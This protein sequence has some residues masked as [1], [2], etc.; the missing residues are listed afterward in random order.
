MSEPVRV[1]FIGLGDQG[2]PMA[3]A[4]AERYPLHVWARRETSYA[5][6]GGAPHST[7]LSAAELAA[8]VD[9]LCLCLR[10]DMDLHELLADGAVLQVLGA[11]KTIINHATGDPIESEGFERLAN[12]GGVRFLDAPV[13]G[14]RPG[15][16]ARSLTCFVGGQP[17]VLAACRSIIA[18]HSST[19]IH[20][21]PV[22]SGQMAK[23]CNNA[24]TISNLR[25]IVE[26]FAMAD[27]LG[28]SLPGLRE[29][30]PEQW[31]QFHSPGAG[32]ENHSG[33]RRPY[34]RS[35]QN[36]PPRI[37]RGFATQR[38]GPD[39]LIPMGN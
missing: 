11:N 2:A 7:A 39:I 29:A 10:K 35:E 33:E 22:G 13:S 23:L 36:R 14:G 16:S 4:I 12:A 25:N 19:I 9:I 3:T 1:G 26:V 28:L 32:R 31:R 5:A 24:L 27:K 20:M 21:G 30:F 18:C 17:D 37:C 6:L 15:A 34:R 8:S 38:L